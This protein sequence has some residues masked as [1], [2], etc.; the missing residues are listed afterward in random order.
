MVATLDHYAHKA[1]AKPDF[2]FA[3]LLRNQNVKESR[4]RWAQVEILPAKQNASLA[5]MLPLDRS[6]SHYFSARDT[7]AE[8]L[9]VESLAA[10]NPAP[11]H[12]KF[13]FYR[14]VGNFAT[15]LRVTMNSGEAI[16]LANTGQEPLAH[17]FVLGLEN[18]VGRFLRAE[19]LAAGAERAIPMDLHRGNAPQ[20]KLSAQLCQE[21]AEA[22]VQEGLYRRE[23][24]AMVNTWKDSWFAE[25]GLRVLYVL[26][27]A[28]TDRTLPM[29]LDPRPRELVRVMVGRAEVITPL[30]AQK[31]SD[32]LVKAKEGD[33][34]ARDQVVAEFRKLGRFAQP[35]WSLATRGLSGEISQTG[36]TLLQAAA[37]PATVGAAAGEP[38][39]RLESRL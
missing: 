20:D 33:A 36:W 23:A 3:S 17:L 5:G 18:G 21:M 31:L 9:R 2:T 15:P 12:E 25:D 24:A 4:V 27:R 14:G 13:I 11:E 7:D 29:A 30:L 38:A 28:W 10:T 32:E 1:G 26:P 34:Q 35:A 6:G 19:S 22:L 37:K 39:A 8:Y 16:T